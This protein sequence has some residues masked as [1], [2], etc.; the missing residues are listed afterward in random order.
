MTRV[1]CAGVFD[2]FHEGHRH[3]LREAKQLGDELWVYLP[4]D[5]KVEM[6]KG[7]LPDDPMETRKK[8]VEASG[9]PDKVFIGEHDPLLSLE[10]SKPDIIALGYDQ[11]LPPCF[12]GSINTIKIVRIDAKNPEKWKSSLMREKKKI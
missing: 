11:S 7:F 1:I 3:F 4:Q 2:H 10:S 9:I 5:D 8:N 12:V 6:Q